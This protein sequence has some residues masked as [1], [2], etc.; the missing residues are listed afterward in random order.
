MENNN[1]EKAQVKFT[2]SGRA[3]VKMNVSP[4]DIRKHQFKRTFTGFDR[5]EVVTFLELVTSDM[6]KLLH[7]NAV[8]NEKINSL[9][10]KN[11]D[12]QAMQDTLQGAMLTAEK[13]AGEKIQAANREADLIVREAELKGREIVDHCQKH[14]ALI[15][16]QI[17]DLKVHRESNLNRYRSFL[18]SALRQ[19]NEMSF[20]EEEKALNGLQ[21][22]RQTSVVFDDKSTAE[23]EIE[24]PEVP[25]PGQA[26]SE[27]E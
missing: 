1:Q 21:I 15:L 23:E 26:G 16:R 2:Y 19:L 24:K 6:E 13:N 18:E 20:E 9:E 27:K 17:S 25:D 3:R 11:R 12:F 14:A 4:L 5:D 10:E 7:E 8:L 22:A